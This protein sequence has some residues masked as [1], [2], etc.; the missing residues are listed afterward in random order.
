MQ[1]LIDVC[2]RCCSRLPDDLDAENCDHCGADLISAARSAG[3]CGGCG[4][5][6]PPRKPG[7]SKEDDAFCGSCGTPVGD[8]WLKLRMLA[9]KCHKCNHALS[10]DPSVAFCGVC[11]TKRIDADT[12]ATRIQ[13]VFR[14]AKARK[15]LGLM[16]RRAGSLKNT[17]GAVLAAAAAAAVE[18][19]KP[20]ITVA[21]ATTVPIKPAQKC[22]GCNATTMDPDAKFCSQC[23]D[24]FDGAPRKAAAQP[25]AA[26][27]SCLLVRSGSTSYGLEL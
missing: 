1:D 3:L 7:D 27:K 2:G 21:R 4:V 14:G 22:K 8:E 26:G 25:I 18:Q 9:G 5:Q 6:L 16:L 23:G 19:A 24:S 17:A 12:A 20:E 15:S 13:K 10:D 11:G